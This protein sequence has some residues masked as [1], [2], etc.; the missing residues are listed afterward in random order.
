[1][2]P[3]FQLLFHEELIPAGIPEFG[4]FLP[5]LAGKPTGIFPGDFQDQFPALTLGGFL[6]PLF[7]ENPGSTLGIL[8]WEGPKLLRKLGRSRTQL[9]SEFP[10]FGTGIQ[11]RTLALPPFFPI[12]FVLFCFGWL[13]FLWKRLWNSWNAVLGGWGEGKDK[14]NSRDFGLVWDFQLENSRRSRI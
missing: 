8:G 6:P 1:M 5:P 7:P 11:S 12:C 2:I 10:E 3:K 14:R 9:R 13:V 4:A